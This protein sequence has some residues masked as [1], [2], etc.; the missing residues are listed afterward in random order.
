MNELTYQTGFARANIEHALRAVGKDPSAV[1]PA[2]LAPLEDF[3]TLGRLATVQLAT[4][5]GVTR[6]D[7]VLDAGT[8]IGGSARFLASE[9]ECAVTGVD[10]TEEYCDTA[11]W[12]NESTGLADRISIIH[13]DVLDLPFADGSFDVI[14]S[15]HVQMN[16]SDKLALYAEACRVLAPGGRLAMWDVTGNADD[17]IYPLPWADD[18]AQSHVATNAGLRA[19]VEAAG[20]HIEHWNDLT[21]PTREIMRDVLAQPPG[22]LGLHVFVRDFPVKIANLVRGFGEGWLEVVQVVASRPTVVDV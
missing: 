22:P 4:L 16:V 8:G 19:A 17:L 9:Y 15:Q 3:H 21:A 6:Q 13:G 12:L 2:D 18:A 11:R 14:F 7:R 1:K 5:A 10:V 20:L